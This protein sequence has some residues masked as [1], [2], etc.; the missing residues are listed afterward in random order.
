MVHASFTIGSG[1]SFY[2]LDAHLSERVLNTA[3]SLT[4]IDDVVTWNGTPSN[5]ECQPPC[6][7]KS[8]C[9]VSTILVLKF[10]RAWI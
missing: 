5:S 7:G 6:V 8:F 4:L 3:E 9:Y 10:P 1:I 2:H